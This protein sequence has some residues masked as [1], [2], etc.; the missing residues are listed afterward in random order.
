[1][2]A[3]LGGK[4]GS[5]KKE[6]GLEGGEREDARRG[7]Q[8]AKTVGWKKKE[9]LQAPRAQGNRILNQNG[10]KDNNS[11]ENA[12]GRKRKRLKEQSREG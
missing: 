11:C 2:F 1:V 12:E 6:G 7:S 4:N 8:G 5:G 9:R 10:I 3:S